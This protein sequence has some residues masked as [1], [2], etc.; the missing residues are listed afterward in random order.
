[1][2]Q[3]HKNTDLLI[4]VG[5]EQ[6]KII[7]LSEREIDYLIYKY[8][9]GACPHPKSFLDE[10][11]KF[12]FASFCTSVYSCRLCGQRQD[13]QYNFPGLPKVHIY[14]LSLYD[15]LA[16]S[17]HDDM[18][19][20]IKLVNH[21]SGKYKFE[22]TTI[23]QSTTVKC[24]SRMVANSISKAGSNNFAKAMCLAL[25]PNELNRL[26]LQSVDQLAPIKFEILK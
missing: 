24:I 4:Q 13:E 6:K 14:D 18:N 8:I 23:E 19:E 20:L 7:D 25:L 1:M 3:P 11:P 21:L 12:G 22:I 16:P 5:N 26:F 10:L 9:M 15:H 2:L 17:Y